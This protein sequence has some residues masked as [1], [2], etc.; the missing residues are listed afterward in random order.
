MMFNN[1][2]I[3]YLICKVG[4][5]GIPITVHCNLFT[6]KLNITDN[7]IFIL[8]QIDGSRAVL[9]VSEGNN[10]R[11]LVPKASV[12]DGGSVWNKIKYF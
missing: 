9:I 11:I 5:T 1:D 10:H 4:F 12:S 6:Y 2:F 8:I 7:L 3:L